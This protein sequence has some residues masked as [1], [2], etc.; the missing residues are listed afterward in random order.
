MN[1]RSLRVS[2]TP[3]ATLHH[4]LK[5]VRSKSLDYIKESIV[6]GEF[7]PYTAIQIS[8]QTHSALKN[9]HELGYI[10]RDVK[11]DNFV[12]GKNIIFVMDFGMSTKFEKTTANL[13]N[14]TRAKGNREIYHA[15]LSIR[16][17]GVETGSHAINSL[18]HPN[19]LLGQLIKEEL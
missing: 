7:A 15:L 2:P 4:E 12:I 9:L 18:E 5:S 10:H 17:E 13:P 8:R 14:R 16:A 6:K 3:L 11:P 19:M 1:V